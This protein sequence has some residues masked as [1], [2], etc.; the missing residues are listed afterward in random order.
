MPSTAFRQATS[1]NEISLSKEELLQ[2]AVTGVLRRIES[3]KLGL[4][5]AHGYEDTGG[6]DDDIEGAAG[7]MAF[8]K[9]RD[10]YW[11]FHVNTFMGGDVGRVHVR[12]CRRKDASLII[13]N[14]DPDDELYVLVI[15]KSPV[16]KIV[17]WILG[18]DSRKGE[19]VRAPNGR[20]PAWFVPQS[21]LNAF[22][23]NEMVIQCPGCSGTTTVRV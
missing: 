19:W 17:G 6:W 23:N 22:K 20:A 12:T 21:V 4:Q 16:Y 13:R 8:A 11:S 9:Y 7:E 2:A 5:D 14:G 3:M 15:G 1:E 18:R 10:R